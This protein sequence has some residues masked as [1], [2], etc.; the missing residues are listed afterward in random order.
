MTVITRTAA[1]EPTDTAERILADIACPACGYRD[2]A[3]TFRVTPANR[4][5]FFCDGCGAFVTILLSDAQ[6]EIVRRWERQR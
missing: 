5:R 3:D 6:A 4:V 1:F 2:P